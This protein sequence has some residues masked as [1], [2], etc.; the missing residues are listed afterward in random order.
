MATGS[1]KARIRPASMR[2]RPIPSAA[3][4]GSPVAFTSAAAM[5]QFW[6]GGRAYREGAGAAQSPAQPNRWNMSGLRM[7]A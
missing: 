5:A 3:R 4:S 2:R 6:H 1:T 7:L